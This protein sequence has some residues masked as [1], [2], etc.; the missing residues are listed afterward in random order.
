LR[1][2]RNDRLYCRREE[3][4]DEAISM[5]RVAG[6]RS[7]FLRTKP[8]FRPVL[9]CAALLTAAGAAQAHTGIG[10]TGGLG[11]GFAHPLGG[12]D[13]VL[14]M[15]AVGMLAAQL[16]GRALWLV[17]LSF[18]AMMIVGGALGMAAI[19]VPLVEAAIGISVVAFGM[20][21]ALGFRLPASAAMVLAGFFALFH[22]YAHGTEMPASLSGLD[23]A[24]GFVLATA[25]LHAAG[26]AIGA[27]AERLGRAF[28][29]RALRTAGSLIAVAGIAIMIGQL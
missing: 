17:P 29:E 5:R 8:M 15:V 4:G 23:Y 2:G 28:G 19:D 1:L 27:A 13:H 21:I 10:D 16:G 3:R 22:G 14:A 25:L 11:Y 9:L 7:T 20:A 6:T 18:I 12:L 26:I 24:A